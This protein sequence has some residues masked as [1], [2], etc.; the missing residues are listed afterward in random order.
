VVREPMKNRVIRV[1]DAVWEAA[2]R[3]ADEKGETVS[4]AVRKFLERYGR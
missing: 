3:K 2:L 1:S 4:E